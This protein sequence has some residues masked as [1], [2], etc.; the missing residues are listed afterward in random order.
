[1]LTGLAAGEHSLRL[2]SVMGDLKV[3]LARGTAYSV[4]VSNLLGDA[5]VGTRKEGAFGS[6]L[7]VT[8]PGYEKAKK[9]IRI[10]ASQVLGDI[11]I[12][13]GE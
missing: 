13:T 12:D 4:Y 5:T 7:E 11:E 2:N 3:R 1:M 6:S 10:R 8:S 9:R